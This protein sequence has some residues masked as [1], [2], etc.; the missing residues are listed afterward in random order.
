MVRRPVSRRSFLVS[1]SASLGV[2][3]ALGASAAHAGGLD[4]G[5]IVA[6]YSGQQPKLWG[7]DIPG[8]TV[9]TFVPQGQEIALTFDACGGAVNTALLDTLVSQRIPA[10]LFL[11]SHWI[12]ANPKVTDSLIANP[13]FEIGNHGTRHV[14]LS[15]TG[16]SAYNIPGTRSPQEVIDEVWTNHQRLTA[17][18]GKP[19]RW[20]RT[21]TAHYDDVAAAIVKD[22]GE[23]PMA[24]SIN[25]D[26]GATAAPAAIRARV[27]AAKP[28]D[29]TI[30][31][32][33]H[34]ESGSAQGFTQGIADLRGRGFTFVTLSES[35]V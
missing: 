31:H 11:N 8:S 20:F 2:A 14:P 5:G 21:G 3:A 4:I 33:N 7:M 1:V 25:G 24:F 35:A 27:A 32:M 15:V 18:M 23:T 16:R 13:L 19:P 28:G 10:T 30:G 6:R 17:L 22:L 34:P 9:C 12:D 26:Y 29:I